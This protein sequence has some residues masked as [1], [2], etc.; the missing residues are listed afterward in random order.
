M[1]LTYYIGELLPQDL[2]KIKPRPASERI[3]NNFEITELDLETGEVK[4]VKQP[5]RTDQSWKDRVD[6]NKVVAKASRVQVQEWRDVH[7][8][9]VDDAS[10]IDVADLTFAEYNNVL[11]Q[12][13]QVFSDLPSDVR[14]RYNND[15]REFLS[16][17]AAD[18]DGSTTVDELLSSEHQPVTRPTAEQVAQ[19]Q[20]TPA[21]ASPEAP[22]EPAE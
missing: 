22:A 11:A 19:P 18:P 7:A 14:L 16:F 21:P 15:A 10:D 13:E 17:L 4:T 20:P 6:L 3:Q 8:K 5:S 12:A 2:K 9:W 1:S